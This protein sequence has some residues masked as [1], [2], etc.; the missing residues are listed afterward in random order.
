MIRFDRVSFTYPGGDSPVLKELSCSV[1][2]GEFCAVLGGN[3]S[4][5]TSL[6]RALT[7]LIPHYYRGSYSGEVRVNGLAVSEQSV[8]SMAREVGYVYQDFE[9]QLIRPRVLDDVCFSPLNYGLSDYRER[10][11]WALELLGIESLADRIVWEL[12]GGERH[13]VALAGALAMDP[14]VLIIDEPISQLDPVF[15]RI[16]YDKLSYLNR[17]R[18]KTILVIEH[19]TEFVG[20]YCDSALLME[21]GRILWKKAPGP[22][23]SSVME[24]D[25]AGLTAPPITRLAHE[26][27]PLCPELKRD[28]SL[29]VSTGEFLDR[30]ASLKLN[31]PPDDPKPV[32]EEKEIL[33]MTDGLCHY[34]NGLEGQK[35]SV[36]EEVNLIVRRGEKIALVGGNGSGKSTLLKLLGGFHSPKSGTLELFPGEGEGKKKRRRDKSRVALVYQQPQE[37][38]IED[39]IRLDAG[40][41]PRSKGEKDWEQ[42]ADR[43]MEDFSLTELSE[44]DGRLLS[45]GQMRRASLAIAAGMEPYLLLLDEPTS[46]LDV[47]SRRLIVEMLERLSHTVRA[48]I[49]ATHDMEL[50]ASWADRVILLREGSIAADRTPTEFFQDRE[51]LQNSR[52]RE[53]Q[54]VELSRKLGLERPVLTPERLKNLFTQEDAHASLA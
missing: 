45:G 23:L 1:E 16:I 51:L 25:R 28:E 35:K 20:E 40:F 43:L 12:S 54:A 7:G 53:P 29:P 52:I 34:Y 26:L 46:S 2:E 50:V 31:L 10:G 15:S 27:L 47:M 5:K 22:A 14:K 8:S 21:E 4:G 13:L 6:S 3:G 37:M 17:E 33:L 18:G 11:E 30:S 9:N 44:R 49:I 48:T 24:L 41:C 32:T 36:L 38:F 42:R 19:F 39:S